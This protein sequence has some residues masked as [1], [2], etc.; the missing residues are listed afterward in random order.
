MDAQFDPRG[1]RQGLVHAEGKNADHLR[2]RRCEPADEQH[3]LQ[4]KPVAVLLE[5]RRVV[6][7]ARVRSPFR[8]WFQPVNVAPPDSQTS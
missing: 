5:D 3:N 1:E 8:Q 7:R 4:L 6:G 2:T